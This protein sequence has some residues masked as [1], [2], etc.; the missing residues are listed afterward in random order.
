MALQ[1][2]DWLGKKVTVAVYSREAVESTERTIIGMETVSDEKKSV[3][4]RPV[5]LEVDGFLEGVDPSGV[6]V[7]FDPRD[8]RRQ[9]GGERPHARPELPPRHVFYPWQ[10]VSLIQRIEEAA[11]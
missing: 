3:S 11:V 6:I 8:V 7:L 5:I 9:P 1:L 2:E 4:E 10:R